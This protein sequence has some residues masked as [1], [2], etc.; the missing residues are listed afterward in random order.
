MAKRVD[1]LKDN[2]SISL[3]KLALPIM[4]MSFLQMAYNLT[5]IFWIGKL[6]AGA[7]ASVGTGGLL[8]WLSIGIHTIAQLGGQVLVG[9]NLG[10]GNE[11]RAGKYAHSSI[12]LSVIC[13]VILGLVFVFGVDF[14]ISFLALNGEEVIKDAKIY[15]IVCCGFVVFQLLAKL[16]TALITT[17]GNS[18]T[19]FI[20]TTIGLVINMALDPL[21]IFGFGFIPPMGVLGAS[22]A[23]VFAQIIV[24]LILV[25]YCLKDKHLF[26][27]VN[28]RKLPQFKKCKEILKL[29]F[30]TTIQAS[31]FPLISMYVSRLIAGYG[32]NAIAVQRVGS[33]IES[34]SWM[35]TEGF[36]IAVNSFIAQ[37]FGAKNIERVKKG[38]YQAL[39]ILSIYGVFVT[40]ILIFGARPIFAIFI[41]EENV[42]AMGVDYLVI[43][44]FSQVF[45][46]LEILSGNSMNALGK[47]TVPAIIS[48]TTTSARIPLAILLSATFLGLNGI[49]WAISLTTVVKGLG[50]AAAVVLLIRKIYNNHDKALK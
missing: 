12:Y 7:V 10:A 8:V 19:P 11:K 44:G 37:N 20:A 35:T 30:P 25:L 26:C 50:L 34:L 13:S 45:L 22:I 28:M 42:V 5:D 49:W 29:S 41:Q 38:F 39:K 36:S 23:T 3:T 21:F 4:G 48:A 17:T 32:D 27:Y 40:A 2:I 47:T 14:F 9:Q 1:L 46:C 24:A 15:I 31:L 43:L 33:Q 6:G 16:L 18:K